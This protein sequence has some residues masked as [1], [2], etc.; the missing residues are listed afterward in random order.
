M[1]GLRRSLFLITLPL[2]T[3]GCLASIDTAK[4][5]IIPDNSLSTEN[6]VVNSNAN[7]D[8]ID[9]GARR[10]ANLFHSFGEFNVREGRAALFSNPAGIDNI[11]SRV[12]GVKPSNIF[13]TLGVADGNANLFFINPNGILFGPDARLDMRGSFLASTANSLLF[14]SGLEFSAINPQE[15]P[16]LAIKIPIGLRFRETPRSITN[17]SVADGVGLK[18]SPG[19]NLSL[20]GGDISLDRGRLTAAGGQ[21]ALGSLAGEGTVGLA[22]DGGLSFPD[23][24]ARGNVLLTNG[25]QIDVTAG[26]GGNINIYAQDLN[27]L[28]N[29]AICAGIGAAPT[30]GKRASDFGSVGSK[31]GNITL[32]TLN[33]LTINQGSQV[34]NVVNIGAIGDAGDINISTKNLNLTNGARL[35]ASTFGKGN[36]GK[37]NIT[38]ADNVKFEGV[39]S[40]IN[41]LGNTISIFTGALSRVE[42]EGKGNGG[43]ITIK[44]KNL[45]LTN[46]ARLYVGIVPG[47]K[48]KAGTINITDA[49]NVKFEGVGSNGFSSGAFSVVNDTGTVNGVVNDTGTVNGVV[50]D[51]GNGNGGNI[52]ISTKSLILTNG[53]RLNASTLGRGNAGNIRITGA[54]TVS[55]DGVGSNQ[56]FSG[57]LSRVEAEGKGNGGD[58][59]ISTKNLK[60]T[61]GARLYVGILPGGKGNAGTINITDTDNVQFD[62]V[63]KNRFSSG[64]FSVVNDTD[65]GNG[66]DINNSTKNLNLT[67]GAVND[68]DIIGNGGDIT[69]ETK[70]LNLT[71]GARLDAS[72][73]GRGNAGN[74]RITGADTVSFDGV[75][76]NQ[77]FS[78]ALS[79]VENKAI[80]NGGDITIETKNLNLTNGARLYVG[81]L[82]E[83]KGKAGTINITADNVKFDGVGKNGFSSGA[84]SYVNEKAQSFDNGSINITTKNLALTNGAQINSSTSGIGKAG[85]ITITAAD[86]VKFDGVG[87]NKNSSGAFSIVE[88]TAKD[89]S[90]GGDITIKTKN[91]NLTN[92]ARLNASTFGKG[93]AGN[94]TIDADNISFDGVGNNTDKSFTGALSR[95]ENKAIG[96]GGDIIIKTK[97]LNLTDGARLYVG[98]LKDANGNAGKITITADN[99]K[100]DGVGKNGFSS[101]AFSYV[102]KEATSSAAA[103]SINI[104]TKNLALTNGAKINADNR[105]QGEEVGNIDITDGNKL[106]LYNNRS[107]PAESAIGKGGN[108]VLG[109]RDILLIR[110]GN[111]SSIG[112]DT[113][114]TFEGN[115]DIK[116]E[117]L[118][119]HGDSE[120]RTSAKAPQGG[121]KVTVSRLH[122][123]KPVVLVSH[124]SIIRAAGELKIE[125]NLKVQPSEIPQVKLVNPSEQ[126]G[127][128][129]CQRGVSS[130]FIITGRGGLP[131]SPNDATSSDAVRVDLVEPALAGSRGAGEQRRRGAQEKTKSSVSKPI[132][133]TQGWIF[134]KN[135]EVMLTAYDPTGTGS[136]RPLSLDSCPVP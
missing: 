126:I 26:G 109:V 122:R 34:E 8:L 96:N 32:N 105:G 65:I 136:Q 72:T 27:I 95:V 88:E 25:A 123:R 119:L 11:L 60:L 16:M 111:I 66:G 22:S 84:F 68:T 103:G 43:D 106:T 94:I 56:L 62:G 125:P 28:E 19:K 92:G 13:G 133:P 116:V 51:T 124:D 23:G 63:G 58:I 44:T 74:I 129:P 40:T 24:V 4:G 18:V 75:G 14:D 31:A 102:D 130:K 101:G 6:S 35:N 127:Q 87:S 17:Q 55:F 114:P 120:I 81:L 100:F 78:G 69:I 57:A 70:N 108:I 131:P 99:V 49:D 77:L 38:G 41:Y 132:V 98:M 115:I 1:Q 97:N 67:D 39:G 121:S 2:A 52:N 118:V 82:K 80:G 104:T 107:L 5:Q 61:N 42:A 89:N 15:P 85:N 128:N 10:G 36:A 12:T 20:V 59:N 54:D 79:R 48:G 73:L 46:G 53:A 33:N 86:T 7:T 71:N 76:S 117:T 83:A 91:L 50:N 21:I 37:I 135:G 30:C 29:S 47:G 113:A 93:N 112:S 64:A 3:L 134:D 110:L 45:N 9:G 90:K